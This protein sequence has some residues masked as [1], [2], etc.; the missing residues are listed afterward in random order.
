MDARTNAKFAP[1]VASR[2]VFMDQG[3]V[4]VDCSTDEFSNRLQSRPDRA[5]LGSQLRNRFLNQSQESGVACPR[6]QQLS[7]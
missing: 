3:E 4:V 1:R 5:R 2:V 6:N 7:A